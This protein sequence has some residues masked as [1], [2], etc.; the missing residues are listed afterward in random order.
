[1]ANPRSG[2]WTAWSADA[3]SWNN[4][5]AFC[6][7]GPSGSK[8]FMKRSN[9]SAISAIVSLE[10]IPGYAWLCGLAMQVAPLFSGQAQVQHFVVRSGANR[11]GLLKPLQFDQERIAYLHE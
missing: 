2:P 11:T 4:S 10:I 8:A 9:N 3:F 7:S 6:A 5:S 1:M